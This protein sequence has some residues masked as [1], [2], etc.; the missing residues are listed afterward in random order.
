MNEITLT[1]ERF[2]ELIKAEKDLQDLKEQLQTKKK[3][4]KKEK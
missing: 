3:R 1:F 4:T 2:E